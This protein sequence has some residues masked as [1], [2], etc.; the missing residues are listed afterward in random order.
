MYIHKEKMMKR[1]KLN[2]EV[3]QEQIVASGHESDR[4]S[5]S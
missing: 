1:E 5:G 2:T 4:E 3:R